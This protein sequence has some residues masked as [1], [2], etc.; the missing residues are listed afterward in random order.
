M[1]SCAHRCRLGW[2]PW[3][4]HQDRPTLQGC[5]FFQRLSNERGHRWRIGRLR[6]ECSKARNASGR[7][8]S[9]REPSSNTVEIEGRSR[10]HVLQARLGQ[11]AI[12]RPAQAEGPHALGQRALYA[13]ALRVEAPAFRRALPGPGRSEGLGFA[14][15]KKGEHATVEAQT[16]PGAAG[17]GRAGA[18]VGGSEPGP[19]RAPLARALGALEPAR[20]LLALR[21]ARHAPVPVHGE[22]GGAERFLGAGLPA[23]VRTGRADQVDAVLLVGHDEVVGADIS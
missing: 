7:E 8:W 16:R 12:A 14:L 21:T 20:A 3:P 13:L 19:D 6:R 10:S 2:R 4:T 18:T 22:V 11:A 23:L 5:G 9:A 1:C 17:P 15:R